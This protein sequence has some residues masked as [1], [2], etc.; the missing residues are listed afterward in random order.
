MSET[1]LIDANAAIDALNVFSDTEHGNRHFL[2]G[3]N[4]AKEIIND[5]PTIDTERHGRWVAEQKDSEYCE[6]RCSECD[7]SFGETDQFDETESKQFSEWIKH[8]PNC[9]RKMDKEDESK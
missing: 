5:A 7:F 4:S 8:C 2:N 6:F 1:R 3:I 9:G